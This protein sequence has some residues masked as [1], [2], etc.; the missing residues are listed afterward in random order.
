[1]NIINCQIADD[2]YQ[3]EKD[4]EGY[5]LEFKSEV[6]REKIIKRKKNEC[7][8]HKVIYALEYVAFTAD[9]V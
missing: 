6:V 7:K 5:N 2:K 4:Q 3:N 9:V 1:M 8:R